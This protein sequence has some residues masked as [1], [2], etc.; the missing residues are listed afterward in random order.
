[1]HI[2]NQF[3]LGEIIYLKT[4]V[5][6]LPRIIIGIQI[7]AD[8]GLIYKCSQGT[9]V[10]WHYEIEMSDTLDILLKTSN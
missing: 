3:E 8:G 7:C 5:E 1:M 10:D 4:E 9:E 6:Q 2:N